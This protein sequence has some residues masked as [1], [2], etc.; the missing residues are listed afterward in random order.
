MAIS[1]VPSI[2]HLSHIYYTILSKNPV[3]TT[4]CSLK[5][6]STP[7][8]SRFLNNNCVEAKQFYAQLK[9]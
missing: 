9:Y 6:C 5:K 2:S 3:Y 7:L 4:I 8:I 1:A